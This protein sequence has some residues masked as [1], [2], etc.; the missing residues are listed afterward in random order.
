MLSMSYNHL[1]ILYHFLLNFII[2]AGPNAAL[3]SFLNIIALLYFQ[4]VP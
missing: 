1:Y 2:F 3:L 4:K